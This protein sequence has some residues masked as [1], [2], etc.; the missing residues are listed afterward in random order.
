MAQGEIRLQDI[1]DALSSGAR[2]VDSLSSWV[3]GPDARDRVRAYADSITRGQ[4]ALRALYST[5]PR[6]KALLEASA[7]E[8]DAYVTRD[9]GDGGCSCHLCAPCSFCT[10]DADEEA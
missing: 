6:A 1:D 10:S 2:A 8:Y 5:W 7:R 9:P 4:A 3:R